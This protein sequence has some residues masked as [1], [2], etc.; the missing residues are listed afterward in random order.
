MVTSGAA[1]VRLWRDRMAEIAKRALLGDLWRRTQPEVETVL[2][3]KPAKDRQQRTLAIL[4]IQYNLNGAWNL[5]R[6]SRQITRGRPGRFGDHCRSLP[7]LSV[8]GFVRKGPAHQAMMTKTIKSNLI[9]IYSYL[10]LRPPF[11][12]L[13]LRCDRPVLM[14]VRSNFL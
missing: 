4:A 1:L 12:L 3:T 10:E 5:R 2:T 13:S 7:S 14:A 6:I 11:F 9:V 8:I